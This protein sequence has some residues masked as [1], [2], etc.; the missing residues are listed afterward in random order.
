MEKQDYREEKPVPLHSLICPNFLSFF[1]GL[2]RAKV[3]RRG[4]KMMETEI[5]GRRQ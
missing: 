1:L 5:K 4:S 3:T 2:M